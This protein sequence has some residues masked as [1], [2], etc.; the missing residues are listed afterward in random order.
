MR[1]RP[2]GVSVDPPRIVTEYYPLGS[3]FALLASAREGDRDVIRS[4]SW[5]R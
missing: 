4:L 5:P 3:L 2:A 1:T